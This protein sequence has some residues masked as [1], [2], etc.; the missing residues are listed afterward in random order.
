MVDQNWF[1]ETNMVILDFIFCQND[2]DEVFK[3]QNKHQNIK[4][5]CVR[6]NWY[7]DNHEVKF[8]INRNCFYKLRLFEIMY[9]TIEIFE[10]ESN[11]YFIIFLISKEKTAYINK[12]CH[13]DYVENIN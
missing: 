10:C 12:Y 13:L 4:I 1:L 3:N 7:F 11:P 8:D 9:V 2:D 6:E 5:S